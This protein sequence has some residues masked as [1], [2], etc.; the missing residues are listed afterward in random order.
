MWEFIAAL[1]GGAAIASKVA[2]DKAALRESSRNFEENQK[3]LSSFRESVTNE[4]TVN[5]VNDYM[6]T[7]G[8]EE[9]IEEEL[10]E[11]FQIIPELIGMEEY[12]CYSNHNPPAGNWF[13]IELVL[14]VKRGCVPLADQFFFTVNP[15][16]IG[17][18]LNGTPK[19]IAISE[20][21]NKLI[22]KWITKKLSMY[23]INI[24]LVYKTKGWI[25]EFVWAPAEE[26]N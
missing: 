18:N 15:Y 17:Q 22:A 7:V 25:N 26:N 14:C 13:F 5:A 23:G 11:L 3:I 9:A 21:S 16:Y 24:A 12:W 6:C 8:N 4:N 10:R 20:E 1:F 2:S 19:Y